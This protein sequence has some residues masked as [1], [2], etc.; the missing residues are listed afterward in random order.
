MMTGTTDAPIEVYRQPEGCIRQVKESVP[1]VDEISESQYVT[2][3]RKEQSYKILDVRLPKNWEIP[4]I[5]FPEEGGIFVNIAPAEYP[6]ETAY[7]FFSPAKSFS[8]I[9]KKVIAVVTYN[10][11][12]EEKLFIMNQMQ[13]E[14]QECFDQLPLEHF[15]K[16]KIIQP[17]IQM[18]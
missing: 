8:E 14:L 7:F 17:Q 2:G 13:R 18:Q 3:M 15:K 11:E 10:K 4:Q 12:L 1:T 16:V 6:E 5:M 9:Y